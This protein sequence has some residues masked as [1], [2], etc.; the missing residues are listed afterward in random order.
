MPLSENIVHL[1]GSHTG[2][3][4]WFSGP[5]QAG[6]FIAYWCSTDHPLRS[7]SLK[8]LQ[9]PGQY[10]AI[11]PDDILAV[12]EWHM[13]S[14]GLDTLSI[15]SQC[16]QLAMCCSEERS[17]PSFVERPRMFAHM[18]GLAQSQVVSQS[19]WQLSLSRN[20]GQSPV[21][22]LSTLSSSKSWTSG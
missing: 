7:L 18:N 20:S 11:R 3:T 2:V 4:M 6:D 1:E 8:A 13:A 9:P 5:R 10:V 14:E 19:N 17:T 22:A 15:C 16:S 21:S 12:Q